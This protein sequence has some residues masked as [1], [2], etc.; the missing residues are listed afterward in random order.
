[1][2]L[3]VNSADDDVSPL[4]SSYNPDDN[5]RGLSP[6]RSPSRP[7]DQRM[8]QPIHYSS[9]NSY[10]ASSSF[11]DHDT[12][13]SAVISRYKYYSKLDG[14]G[15]A[16]TMP[17]HVVPSV[18]II[19]S[20][21]RGSQPSWVTIFSL[22]NTMM[23]TSLLSM[24]WAINQAGFICGILLLIGMAGLM[25]YTSYRILDA[26][27]R[28]TCNND[29]VIEFSDVCR[30]YLGRWAEV[31]AFISSLLTLLGGM[32]VYWIL[33]SNFL[34]NIVSF[35][36]HHAKG[37]EGSSTKDSTA[38]ICPSNHSGSSSN[39]SSTNSSFILSLLHEDKHDDTFS[40]IWDE[41]KTVPLMLIA[42]V[43]P[44]INFKSPTFFTK[45]NA[46]GTISVTYLVIFVMKNA[47][48]WG[49]HLDFYNKSSP[50][51]VYEFKTSFPY[52]S[53]ISALAYFVQNCVCAVTRP[54][55]HPENTVRD[56]IIAYVLVAV[57]YLY[58]GVMVY[59]SFGLDKSCIEDN[60]L[61]NLADTNVMAFVARIGL[62]FQMMCVFPLL[63][64]I[65]RLQ[66][67]NSLFGSIWPSLTHVLVLNGTLVAVCVVF[68]VFLPHIGKIIGFVGA[69]CGF[70]YAIALPCLAYMKISATEGTLT[71]MKIIVHSTLIVLGFANFVGQFLLLG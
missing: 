27:K 39:H 26:V 60:F 8:R 11:S 63:V 1:M 45:F 41:Q 24:P 66:F 69:F 16:L 9:I 57:T 42:L 47:I 17:D 22:W 50:V 19:S 21:I 48:S 23:G 62:L 34:Y 35:I 25:L 30:A 61:N 3:N 14:T 5:S 12:Q 55:K 7:S 54:Q 37:D 59:I 28:I 6:G 18:F 33:I 15:S 40:K 29:D 4:L 13:T 71:K 44:L 67:M 56:L 38:P 52:L 70:S 20:E 68:A 2:S 64:F 10:G 65:F 58:V 36:Y 46:L 49:I 31:V 43:F 32:I 53:G 51:Y